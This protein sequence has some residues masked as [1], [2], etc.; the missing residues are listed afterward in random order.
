MTH[1]YRAPKSWMNK[2]VMYSDH[3]LTI[4]TGMLEVV[5]DN[6]DLPIAIS[7]VPVLIAMLE[8]GC[9]TKNRHSI[10]T[11]VMH[12]AIQVMKTKK[13]RQDTLV[14]LNNFVRKEGET[15]QHTHQETS[16]KGECH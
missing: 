12:T 4:I 13:Q 16:R 5:L 14:K 1:V 15:L 6:T 7:P 8:T 11:V 9:F 10:D 2:G 3:L